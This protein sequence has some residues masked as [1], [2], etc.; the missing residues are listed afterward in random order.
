MVDFTDDLINLRFLDINGNPISQSY[1]IQELQNRGV[2][3]EY[4]GN[5]GTN[6]QSSQNTSNFNNSSNN[7]TL[8][9]SS[10]FYYEEDVNM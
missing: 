5:I 10:S 6:Q 4:N 9:N 8:N 3:V 2:E 7:T 1:K